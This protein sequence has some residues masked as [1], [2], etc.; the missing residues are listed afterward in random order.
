MNVPLIKPTELGVIAP[1]EGTKP[2]PKASLADSFASALQD[3]HT[4]EKTATT[5]EEQFAKGDAG[6]GIHE[7]MIAT[8]KANLSIRYVTT[9]KNKAIEAYRE[10]L[11]TQV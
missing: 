8:E 4:A 6:M 3:A 11:N 7:V 2:A 9:V 5:A 10:L 1:I